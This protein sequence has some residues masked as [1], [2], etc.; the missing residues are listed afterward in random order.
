MAEYNRDI[1][2][3]E[4]GE[5]DKI[6]AVKEGTAARLAVIDAAIKEEEAKGL[7]A[8]QHFHELMKQRE[9]EVLK[10]ADVEAKAQA[11]AASV[12]AKATAAM[13]AEQSRHINKKAAIKQGDGG[14]DNAKQI[15]LEKMQEEQSYA[16][17]AAALQKELA[18]YKKAGQDRVNQAR[19]VQNQLILLEQQHK[20]KVDELAQQES[21]AIK[22]SYAD[23]GLAAAIHS[24]RCRGPS[25]P[26]SHSAE[27]CTAR[28]GAR[29]QALFAE[30][31]GQKTRKCPCECSGSKSRFRC[32]RCA[33][34]WSRV[35]TRSRCQRVCRSHGF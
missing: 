9:Q 18:L 14:S 20:D 26:C 33:L 24:S 25:K 28:I 17:K 11:E 31:A 4:Q 8:T 2:V 35:G 29:T 21:K 12:Q 3:M 22:Q 32:C 27:V 23:M 7:Q 30:M 34:R 6:G 19:D 16:A 5:S 1:A 13:A 15:A 10:E